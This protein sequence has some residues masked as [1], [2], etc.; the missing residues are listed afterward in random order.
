MGRDADGETRNDAHKRD[1]DG[2]W[3]QCWARD[4]TVTVTGDGRPEVSEICKK[5]SEW[6]DGVTRR[7]ESD[8]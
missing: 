6:W 2:G 8:G 1:A 3:T 5:V 7:G 4:E